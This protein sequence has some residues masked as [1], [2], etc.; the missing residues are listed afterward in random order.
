M[1]LLTIVPLQR[2][3]SPRQMIFVTRPTVDGT[4]V[5]V[6]QGTVDEDS[7]IFFEQISLLRC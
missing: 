6:E 7:I 3:L 5:T 1:N 2:Q 4:I